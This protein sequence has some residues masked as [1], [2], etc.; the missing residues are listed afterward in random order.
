MPEQKEIYSIHPTFDYNVVYA[1]TL[2]YDDHKGRIKIGETTLKA[3]IYDSAKNDTEK[4]K[5]IINAAEKR[6]DEQTETADVEYNLLLS[7]LAINNKNKPFRD[8]DVHNVLKR[9]G[10]E[11][12]SIRKGPREWFVVDKNIVEK[13]IEAVK[14]GW[15]YIDKNIQ[16]K[17]AF[18]FRD[19]QLKAIDLAVKHFKANEENFLWNAKM[20]FGKTSAALQVV[21]E[22]NFKK[23]LIITHRP[24]VSDGWFDDFN[25]VFQGAYKF[26][27]KSKGETIENLIKGTGKFVYFA[28][29]Q[30]LRGS[31]E[32][33]KGYNLKAD[34]F[35]KNEEIFN[36]EWDFLIVDEAH[37]GT[38]SALGMILNEKISRKHTLLLSGTP[39]NLLEKRESD[40]IYTWDYVMEQEA[41]ANWDKTHAG[42]PNPY[43]ALPRLSMFVYDLLKELDSKF[44][45]IE[46]SAFNF[47]EFFRVNDKEGDKDN[48]KLIHEKSVLKFLNLITTENNSQ[49]PYSTKEYR[50]Y[51][52]HSLWMVPGVKEAAA[53]KE[54]LKTHPIFRNFGVANVAGDGDISSSALK[55]VRKTIEENEY[56][57]TITCG[58]LT[59]GVNVPEW[60]AVFMLS[61]TT[62]AT[63]YLQTAF[64]CQTPHSEKGKMK[65]ECYVFDFAPDRTLKIVAEAG[66]LRTKAGETNKKE[67]KEYMEKFLNFCPIISATNGAMQKYNVNEMLVKLKEV[68]IQRVVR[69]GFDDVKLYNDNLL[70]LDKIALEDFARLRQIIGS[71]KQ[72]E[73]TNKIIVN[74]LG[75]DNEE[76]EKAMEAERKPKKERTKEEQAAYEKLQEQKKQ[77]ATAISILR[78]ISI[79]IPMLIFG[80]DIKHDAEI[81]PINFIKLVDPVSWQEFMPSGVTKAEFEKFIKYYDR[82][83]FIGSGL[84]IR[85][86]ALAADQLPPVERVTAIAN[87]F[88]T[89]KNPDK[90]TVLTPWK[91]VNMHI[92]D[93]LG[94]N[95]FNNLNSNGEP[96]WVNQGKATQIW[97]QK[98][99]FIF[100][101]NS[102]SGL[103]PLLAA[104]NIY[105]KQYTVAQ[106]ASDYKKIWKEVLENNIFVLC[107]TP[108]AVSITKRTL[109][110]YGKE[111]MNVI[112]IDNLIPKLKKDGSYKTFDFKT[113][114]KNQVKIGEDDMTFDVV[115]GNPP[116]QENDGGGTGSSA[117]A[118]YDKFVE[119][120]KALKPKYISMIM[121]SRWM[122]GG[123][124]LD[125]FREKNIKDQRWSVIHDYENDVEVF[126]NTDIGGG[127]MYFLWDSKHTGELDYY[128]HFE[129]QVVPSKRFL[130]TGHSIIVRNHTAVNIL[131]N[132]NLAKGNFSS[133]VSARKPYGLGADITRKSSALFTETNDNYHNIKFYAWDGTPL[134][135]YI[136]RISL[137]Q[138][139]GLKGEPDWIDCW[140]V[141][142]SKSGDPYYRFGKK[143]KDILRKPF[144]GKPFTA[145]SETYLLIGPFASKQEAENVEKYIR[146]KL[147]R[148]LVLQKKKTQ[149]ISKELFDLVPL[150][151]FT[152]KSAVPWGKTIEELDEYFFNLYRLSR[153]ERN[154]IKEKINYLK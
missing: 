22:M 25:K 141:F 128:E 125:D 134:V 82:D 143:N 13:A 139:N 104:Y 115:I 23:T 44:I 149:N 58:R 97:G 72:A 60:T 1:Y 21:K 26:G 98:K 133:L 152:N 109:A 99:V 61:N 94:G 116:Y 38:Q 153:N 144:L 92:S 2:P 107:K 19:S 76:Y 83:V 124:G 50:N 8:I 69:N 96:T 151:D 9:S 136:K 40:E 20:R 48:G 36:T 6:I 37:E 108:M 100:E 7:H 78:G 63:T 11:K 30:D 129:G 3:A 56:S 31:K 41:K 112:Y 120:A 88:A 55:L 59:M 43:A 127:V 66:E 87:I 45:D 57:I 27:S 89:F 32:V 71:S 62:S 65:T 85:R 80:A 34:G 53:L 15:S 39:F 132:I 119:Q 74:D 75:F 126:P 28:S 106:K 46:D 130:Y 95:N 16:V 49:F 137:T 42:E 47:R 148:F 110:G 12:K 138:N 5:A 52:K 105:D 84:K 145:C 122:T 68:A 33:V 67:Q 111:K 154:F 118:I 51:I 54:L 93:T 14:N 131:K 150:Q 73:K 86:E 91:V 17:E 29:I 146:T 121:P 140:K 81:D 70:K 10:Y 114:L 135:K 64:R 4:Q 117:G 123:K 103:Y 24:A 90:E 18:N 35:E 113:E 147:F 102:K 101:I 142:I 77:R 79:R